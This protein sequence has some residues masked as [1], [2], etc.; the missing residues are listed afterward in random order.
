MM[1][2]LE[3]L[4]TWTK[5][6]RI[7]KTSFLCDGYRTYLIGQLMFT[8]TEPGHPLYVKDEAHAVHVAENML[9][10]GARILEVT[11]SLQSTSQAMEVILSALNTLRNT[12]PD[13][14]LAINTADRELITAVL[15][16]ELVDLVTVQEWS[17][18]EDLMKVFN[19]YQE[20]ALIL[21]NDL[22][23][24]RDIKGDAVESSFEFFNEHMQKFG[25]N[26]RDNVILDLGIGLGQHKRKEFVLLGSL[27]EFRND[28]E[29]PMVIT[30]QWNSYFEDIT[31]LSIEDRYSPLVAFAAVA[32][33]QGVDMIRTR[34]VRNIEEMFPV[35]ESFKA[36]FGD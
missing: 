8:P 27:A 12:F 25:L 24:S 3:P 22:L 34:D 4:E 30:V 15:G 31:Q 35:L 29:V 9:A 14:P 1:F 32:T 7:G 23:C 17:S 5:E 10:Y 33:L 26:D 6:I 13:V 2:S 18:Q 19:D 20:I 28:L 11:T 36:E 21:S 16:K